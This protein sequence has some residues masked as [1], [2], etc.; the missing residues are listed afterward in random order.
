MGAV[1]A[2]IPVRPSPA[3]LPLVVRRLARLRHESV[4]PALIVLIGM[5]GVA[6][7]ANWLPLP[8]PKSSDLSAG[9]LPPFQSAAHPLGTDPIGR[10]ILSRL[11]FGARISLTVGLT[12][13]AISLV[14][15]TAVGVMAGFYQGWVDIVFMRLGDIWLS[16]PAFILALTIMTIFG[17]G[18]K[19]VIL[20]L[21]I[22]G[23]VRYARVARSNVLPLHEAEY[24]IASRALGCSSF[25]IMWRHVLP[26]VISPLIVVATLGVGANIISEASLS[27]LGLGVDPQTPS[28]GIMLANGRDYLQIAPW[29]AATPGIAI[30]LTVLATNLVGDW[31]RDELDPR[32]KV[33]T[34]ALAA[35]EATPPT[36]EVPAAEGL[37]QGVE[38]DV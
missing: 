6:V 1:E 31:L 5:V 14:V 34:G 25:R 32:T 9:L 11:V 19:N 20:A 37:F 4:L 22:A 36:P 26:N 18:E 3:G 28:W 35:S 15:G 8:D 29:V 38:V 17:A 2:P 10:D 23:W 21:S 13:V 12:S 30:S 27:F 7:I 33:R 16:L 24:V